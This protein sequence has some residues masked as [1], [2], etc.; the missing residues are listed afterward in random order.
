[1]GDNDSQGSQSLN[2]LPPMRHDKLERPGCTIH[3]WLGGAADRPLVVFTHGATMDHAM[4]DEQVR[5]LLPDYRVLTWDV[6]GHGES[7]PLQGDFTLADCAADLIALLDKVGVEQAVLVGQSM[8]GYISQYAYLYH[9]ERVQAMVIIGATSIAL[10]Y[11]RMEI[12]A[13]KASL[14]L[15]GIWPF[16]HFKRT[17]AKTTAIKPEIRAYA[18]E[19]INKL[20]HQEFLQIWKAVTLAIKEEGIPGHQIRVPLLLTHGD[21]DTTGVIRRDA[22]KWAAYEPDVEYVV[23][24]HAAHNAN[25]DNPE[26]FNRILL[27][28]LGKHILQ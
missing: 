15:F 9:P 8:G 14:P 7:R 5:A 18:L 19:T 12:I 20:S 2:A 13:L 16:G 26:F 24:P 6:R 28:F 21:Q 17:V 11:G 1:M 3:Y 10:P 27:E 25:Q 23:I 22:P 4:F